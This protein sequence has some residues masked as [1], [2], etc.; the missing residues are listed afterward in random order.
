MSTLQALS[1]L[2]EIDVIQQLELKTRNGQEFKIR[3]FIGL[4]RTLHLVPSV[5]IHGLDEQA[6]LSAVEFVRKLSV[7]TRRFTW[8]KNIYTTPRPTVKATYCTHGL[9]AQ[10]L[11]MEQR[12]NVI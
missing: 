7:W 1:W 8:S 2:I 5:S 4:L 11:G 10:Y 6:F 12:E 9:M 3:F